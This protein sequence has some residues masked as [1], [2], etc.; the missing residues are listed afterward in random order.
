MLSFDIFLVF[1]RSVDCE[2]GRSG[3]VDPKIASFPFDEVDTHI[4]VFFLRS[5]TYNHFPDVF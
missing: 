3:L 1:P 2:Y 4:L 5:V